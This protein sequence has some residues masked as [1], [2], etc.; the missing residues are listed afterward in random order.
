MTPIS[1]EERIICYADKFFSK[2]G[3]GGEKS[4]EEIKNGLAPYGIDKVLK[5]L[6]FVDLFG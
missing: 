3:S 1:L 4:V 6:G 2:N 5:F